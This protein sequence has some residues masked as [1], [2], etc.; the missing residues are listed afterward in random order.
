MNPD[1]VKFVEACT[2]WGHYDNYGISKQCN[3]EFKNIRKMY[4]TLKQ[5]NRLDELLELLDHENPYVRL[6][7]AT[8]T[9]PI[10]TQ[11]AE[12]TLENLTGII[13][14]MVGHVARMT[15]QEWRNGHMKL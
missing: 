8:C 15:L 11:R 2:R 1:I 3:K 7:A 14:S 13:K 9:L 4:E 5:E 6:Y 10:A 12:Q